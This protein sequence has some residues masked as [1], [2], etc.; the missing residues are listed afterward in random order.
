MQTV[1]LDACAL[2]AYIHREKGASLVER[3]LNDPGKEIVMHV[4]N[5]YEVYYNSLRTQ[6]GLVSLLD[7]LIKKAGIKIYPRLDKRIMSEGAALKIHYKMSL[8]DSIA[9][10]LS[11][12]L[13]A[14]LLTADRH[15]FGEIAQEKLVKIKFIR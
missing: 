11:N 1:V 8:A 14:T 2:I 9:I 12:K 6:P 10:G 15:E 5:F 4:V 13:K 7:E 3:H